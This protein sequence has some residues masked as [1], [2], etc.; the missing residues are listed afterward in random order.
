LVRVMIADDHAVV[1]RG[2]A[3]ILNDSE[4][5]CVVT[6]ANDAATA[7]AAL[8]L[9]NCDILLL[10]IAMPGR[11]GL[12][13][14][15]SVRQEFPQVKVLVLSMY[16]EDQFG[17]RA[18][19]AGAVGYLN[20]ASAPDVLLEAV[21]RVASGRRYISPALAELLAE[22]VSD[23]DLPRYKLL[24]DREFQ[25]LKLIASGKQLSQIAEELHLSPKTVSGYRG[26][27]MD[28][29]KFSTN[30]ELTRYAIENG[31]VE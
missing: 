14:L 7:M 12:D 16:P 2:L 1:R 5:A 24:S 20:K 11:N 26:R 19:K 23:G 4:V 17:L 10:D 13:T 18:L 30:A 22:S 8:R 15:K 25:T 21:E 29:M 28:K 6:E 9:G 3:Q 31:L 27:L